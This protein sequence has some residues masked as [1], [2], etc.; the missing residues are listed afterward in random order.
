MIGGRFRRPF[1][2]PRVAEEIEPLVVCMAEEHATWGH[3][4]IQGALVHLGGHID[5]TTVRNIL[6]RNHRYIVC[7]SVPRKIPS[8]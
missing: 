5:A 4:R 3:R 8:L 1:R 6:R 2:R 7:F